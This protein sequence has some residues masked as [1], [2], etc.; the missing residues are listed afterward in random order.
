MTRLEKNRQLI[1]KR[2]KKRRSNLCSKLFLANIPLWF[3]I[4]NNLLIMDS[5]IRMVK[6]L[7]SR[8]CTMFPFYT[9]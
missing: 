8:F 5:L 9:P 3:S 7:V 4:L 2:D 1:S 6:D